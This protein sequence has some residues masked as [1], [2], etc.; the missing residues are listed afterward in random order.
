M[1]MRAENFHGF[2]HMMCRAGD[3][4][5]SL[6]PG[7]LN[8]DSR[9]QSSEAKETCEWLQLHSL[10]RFFN[11]L[12]FW[13]LSSSIWSK[14]I[15]LLITTPES[16]PWRIST[17][18]SIFR[19]IKI[20]NTLLHCRKLRG[21]PYADIM[22]LLSNTR[23]IWTLKGFQPFKSIKQLLLLRFKA[24]CRPLGSLPG[25]VTGDIKEKG[26]KWWCLWRFLWAQAF[27]SGAAGDTEMEM[28]GWGGLH[29][30]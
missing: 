26:K 28:L 23:I 7:Y 13:L 4:H 2:M 8:M 11:M 25:T 5:G 10:I 1:K 16:K 21:Q 15:S 14:L 30:K 24:F 19:N 29:S 9:H 27:I 6:Q 3:M 17:Q 22:D 18:Q 20:Q 12:S